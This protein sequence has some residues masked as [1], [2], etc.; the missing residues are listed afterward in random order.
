VTELPSP[1]RKLL[2][3]FRRGGRFLVFGHV[4]PDGD[5]VASQLALAGFLRRRGNYVEV[6]SAGPF[7][8][9]ETAQFREHFRSEIRA[10]DLQGYPVAVVLDCS[11]PERIGALA[12]GIEGL[13]TVVIDHH[14]AGRDFGSVRWVVPE[15]PS[16]SFLVQRLIESFPAKP[17]SEEAELLLF[18]LATDTGFF[19]HLEQGSAG[20][21]AAVARLSEAGASPRSVYRRIHSGWRLNKV[22]LL[23]R[24]L[25]RARFELEERVLITW[26]SVQGVEIVAFVQEEAPGSCAVGLRSNGDFDVGAL[27]ADLGGGGHKRAAGYS[28]KGTIAEVE[29]HLLAELRARLAG[30]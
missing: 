13:P 5:C 6:F 22:R 30:L 7:D 8:R 9:P 2:E 4:E 23:A 14:A 24:S 16:T 27:A 28:R 3:Q 21:F 12:E 11:T 25:E 18:G 26:Q 10:A 19:R 17:T 1:P 20:V 15:A 29:A